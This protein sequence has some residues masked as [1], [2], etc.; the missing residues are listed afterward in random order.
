VNATASGTA[1]KRKHIANMQPQMTLD[2]IIGMVPSLFHHHPVTLCVG[3]YRMV[4][5]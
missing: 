4:R 1:D 5:H 2:I 3:D